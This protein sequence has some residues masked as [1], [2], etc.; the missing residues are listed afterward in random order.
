MILIVTGNPPGGQAA[1]GQDGAR[2]PLRELMDDWL[3]DTLLERSR[4]AAGGCG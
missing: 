1:D 2:V 3:L 4:D